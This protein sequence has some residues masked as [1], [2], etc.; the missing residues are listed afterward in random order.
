MLAA[1]VLVLCVVFGHA[2]LSLKNFKLYRMLKGGKWVRYDG[3]WPI[4]E[5]GYAIHP[6]RG[7]HWRFMGI[8][9]REDWT[10]TAQWAD[11]AQV[12][13]PK[14]LVFGLAI[15]GLA[16]AWLNLPVK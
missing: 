7:Y 16:Y 4:G 10:E 1:M 9:E 2:R 5:K 12:L 15:Y 11:A 14:A 13:V 8:E 6:G 3:W